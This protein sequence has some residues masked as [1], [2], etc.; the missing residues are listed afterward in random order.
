V[1]SLVP[2]CV[3]GL[4]TY[5]IDHVSGSAT[6]TVT[7]SITAS[8]QPT[9][10]GSFGPLNGAS[11]PVV[12]TVNPTAASIPYTITING[13]SFPPALTT[14]SCSGGGTGGE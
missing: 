4:V 2:S 5:T 7:Y 11:A 3:G 13:F 14:I 1:L 10:N 12:I 6:G 9:V 8:G